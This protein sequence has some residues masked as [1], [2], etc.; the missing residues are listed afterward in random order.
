MSR[1]VP[2]VSLAAALAT[3][4]A[5]P[6]PSAAQ[7]VSLAPCTVR[8]LDGDVRCGTVRVPENR[9]HPERRQIDLAIVVAS[10]TGSPR[11]ADPFMLL[12]GG[13]GQAG[14]QMG[15]FATQ[16][17]A[18][19]REHRD[20]VLIDTRGTGRS[21]GLRC[22]MMRR[23]E[24]LGGPS[25]FPDASVRQCRDSLQHVADLTQYT[26]AAIADDIEAV[27][28]ALGV[29][30]LNLYG[31]SYGT[32]VALVYLRR[33]PTGVRTIVLKAVAPPTL[34]AP[35]NYAED[36]QRALGL[37]ERDCLA[38]SACATLGSPTRNLERTLA[39]AAAGE[40]RVAAPAAIS[41]ARDT[42][43][44][45]RD[46]VAASLVGAMQSAGSRAQLPLLLR[47]AADGNTT[48]LAALIVQ[49]RQLLDQEIS[50]GM[51]LSVS[52]GEDGR[53]IDLAR[54]RR[55]DGRTFLGSAR[56]RML[57]GAC[58]GWSVP[59]ETPG[60][61]D[62]VRATAPVLLVSGV[63][64][65]NTPPRHAESALRTLPNGRHVLLDGV[66]HGWSN[67]DGCG[68][69]FVADFV[70]RA[71]TAELDVRCGERSSAP[72]FAVR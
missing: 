48:P 67:V 56:V 54:A 36:A 18:R 9:A 50:S 35:M 20:L 30:Q 17:F 25:M 7:R 6:A 44:I 42:V 10:A 5:M 70:A 69:A 64:D 23:P 24:D 65:P 66:A 59:P 45:S 53:R 31:T 51:F 32:R 2:V 11:A 47:Q 60:A 8:G 22:A 39:R 26:T 58:A 72:P 3:M 49:Y 4:L 28:E 13:P 52:C 61:Y 15:P 29:P 12:A 62:P 63:L 38:D 16:A 41:P 33:H 21:N 71:S 68:A 43:T 40:I 55:D 57:A 46:A 37:L 34:I 1:S 19:V 14:S 27:R